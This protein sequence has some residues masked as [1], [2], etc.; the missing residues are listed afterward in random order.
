LQP[1]DLAMRQGR[2]L[3]GLNHGRSAGGIARIALEGRNP[4]YRP[5]DDT[6]HDDQDDDLRPA[7]S[8]ERAAG[9]VGHLQAKPGFW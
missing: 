2:N 7:K 6:C 1:G 4:V 9:L 5:G 3:A 8:G